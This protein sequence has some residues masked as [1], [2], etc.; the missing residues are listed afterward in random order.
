MSA[1]PCRRRTPVAANVDPAVSRPQVA[2]RGLA[3]LVVQ[4]T[5][6]SPDHRPSFAAILQVPGHA[7]RPCE[8]LHARRMLRLQCR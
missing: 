5:A 4:C 1:L 6:F 8:T 7:A 3:D 2:I